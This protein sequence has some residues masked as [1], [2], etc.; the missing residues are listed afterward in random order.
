MGRPKITNKQ[1]LTQKVTFFL[2][3]EAKLEVLFYVTTRDNKLLKLDIDEDDANSLIDDFK[4]EIKRVVID[5]EYQIRNYSTSEDRKNCY[6][7]YDLADVPNIFTHIEN[8][9]IDN[10]VNVF[11]KNSTLSDLTGFI[12]VFAFG[13]DIVKLY[14]PI[15][16]VD[17]IITKDRHVYLFEDDSR[18]VKFSKEALSIS[19]T[20][21]ILYV[22]KNF[23]IID[24]D[25][26]ER[27]FNLHQIVTN[28]A[29]TLLKDLER[30]SLIENLDLISQIVSDN[31]RL[32][33]KLI[34]T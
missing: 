27:S 1:E 30:I 23:V 15:Y 18:F 10:D 13:D 24:I 9:A 3:D 5:S 28:E 34:C 31:V 33:K 7:V 14:R 11:D 4:K 32:A 21:S 26:V 22:D 6:F 8:A 2:T 29:K 19:P 17:K 12:T 20:F 16:N 25:K